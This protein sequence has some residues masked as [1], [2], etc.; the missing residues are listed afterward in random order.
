[1]NPPHVLGKFRLLIVHTLAIVILI[2]SWM[3]S[4][5]FF[6][7]LIVGAIG[8]GVI[9][10]L[11]TEI[12]LKVSMSAVPAIITWFIVD[13]ITEMGFGDWQA[14]KSG[15]SWVFNCFGPVIAGGIVWF[16]V[17]QILDKSSWI[18]TP[19]P[20]CHVRGKTEKKEIHKEYLGQKT[21]K[22]GDKWVTYNLYNVTY[23]NWCNS[24]GVD[25]QTTGESRE[26]A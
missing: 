17:Y 24:C 16:W 20:H 7:A 3:G 25:W 19:C 18:G 14:V 1:M 15:G 13:F 5:N 23:Q 9:W 22:S 26:R 6:Q 10:V 11:T 12:M 21:E 2:L 4:G 8:W